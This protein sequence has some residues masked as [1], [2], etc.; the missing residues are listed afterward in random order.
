MIPVQAKG[1][2][3][4]VGIVQINQDIRY[5]EQKFPG[6]RCKPV[7]AQFMPDKTIALFELEL[8]GGD[9]KVAEEKHYRL[10]PANE[11]DEATIR[12]YRN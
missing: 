1:G 4:Q 6:M 2:R 9:L 8:R 7:A 10:V 5:C 12:T 11:I 3:D